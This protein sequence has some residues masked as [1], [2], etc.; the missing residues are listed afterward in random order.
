MDIPSVSLLRPLVNQVY[1]TWRHL[2]RLPAVPIWWPWWATILVHLPFPLDGAIVPHTEV[3]TTSE[4]GS[5]VLRATPILQPVLQG[6]GGFCTHN[7]RDAGTKWA[8]C[9][10]L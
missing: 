5:P 10:C 1:L 9:C 7:S 2:H 6:T 8:L 4:V 3:V